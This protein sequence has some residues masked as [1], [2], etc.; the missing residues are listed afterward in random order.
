MSPDYATL[1]E[2]TVYELVDETCEEHG[3]VRLSKSETETLVGGLY[4][5]YYHETIAELHR[6]TGRGLT[7][8]RAPG[9]SVRAIL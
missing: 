8:F 6:E 9:G 4:S 5:H 2:R 3:F 7:M 1:F